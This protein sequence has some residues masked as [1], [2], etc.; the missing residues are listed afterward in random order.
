MVIINK[1]TLEL[2][3]KLL[4]TF[5]KLEFNEEEH[6]YT[7]NG[8]VL[9]SVSSLLS[10]FYVP[11]DTI[12]E[13][14]RYADR[15]NFLNKD[16][17]DAWQGENKIATD[18]GHKVHTFA[19]DYANWRYWGIGEKPKVSCKQCLGVIDFYNSLPEHVIPIVLELRMYDEELGYAGTAD[20][21]LYD[22]NIEKIYL[23]DWKSNK[24]IQEKGFPQKP[25]L[26]LP[27]ELGLTQDNF[28]KYSL[29]FSFYQLV[30]ERAGFPIANRVLIWLADDKEN[31][32]LFVK[33]PTKNLTSYLL[34]L[35]ETKKIKP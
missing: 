26:H 15:R 17:A 16:V 22:T 8:K 28:G 9:P 30:L 13:A 19:E 7:L 11:F 24:T 10:N 4:T 31:K 18:K 2:R 29:Q 23:A 3:E 12:S 5:S 32:K 25:L 34:N 1:K 21:I 6:K 20:I 27:K 35:I 14:E 33:M